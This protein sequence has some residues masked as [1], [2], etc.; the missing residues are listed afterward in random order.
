MIATSYFEIVKILLEEEACQPMTVNTPT[1][2]LK[3]KA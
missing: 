1:M 2:N 3:T